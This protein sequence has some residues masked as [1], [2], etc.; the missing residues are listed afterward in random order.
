MI[1]KFT[2]VI[3]IGYTFF[4]VILARICHYNL[5]IKLKRTEKIARANKTGILGVIM[6][7]FGL[8]VSENQMISACF[9]YIVHVQNVPKQHNREG[10]E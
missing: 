7:V 5:S 4:K 3:K 10:S 9:E 8:H 6:I 2:K 1:G